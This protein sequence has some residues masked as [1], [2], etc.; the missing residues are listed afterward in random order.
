MAVFITAV[1][2]PFADRAGQRDPTWSA[3]VRRP[4]RG[5]QI[6]PDSYA[7]LRVV[8]ADGTDVLL[9]DSSSYFE[10]ESDGIGRSNSF[11]NFIVQSF[12]DQRMEKQQIVQTFGEDYIFF[13][14]EQPR[15]VNVSGLLINTKD[16]NWKNEFLE[17]YERYLRGTRL[18]ENNA[19]LYFYVDD[20]V[21]EG[22]LVNSTVNMTADQP[23]LVQFSFQMFVCQ[24]ATLSTTGSIFYQQDSVG[25]PTNDIAE[26]AP[27]DIGAGLAANSS[28]QSSPGGLNS[29]LAEAQKYI[30][31]GEVSIQ[32]ALE[33]ARNFLYADNLVFSGLDNLIKPSQL[34]NQAS[35]RAAP[36]NQPIY[37]QLDEYPTPAP[38]DSPAT[39][40]DQAE[41]QRINAIL[42]LETP[43]QLEARARKE[44]AAAGIDTNSREVGYAL[45]GRGAF[46]ALQVMATFGFAQAGGEVNIADEASGVVL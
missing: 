22:Y 18:V 31:T 2:D 33:E 17:N 23:Y 24:Y 16:F 8:R 45:L 5:I 6:K 7:V 44:L 35:F 12:S 29:F 20:V 32:K 15:F 25:G 19:R 40:L 46:A 42:A 9:Y 13:F 37:T 10:P 4:F 14:G 43:E 1:T 34:T 3:T 26:S 41:I 21:M 36:V 38:I 30:R 11:A 27:K 28:A 39:T